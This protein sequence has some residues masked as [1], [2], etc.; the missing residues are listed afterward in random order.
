MIAIIRAD[1]KLLYMFFEA[2]WSSDHPALAILRLQPSGIYP[3]EALLNPMNTPFQRK[4]KNRINT[5]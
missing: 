1:C 5:I 3:K 2:G 4:T